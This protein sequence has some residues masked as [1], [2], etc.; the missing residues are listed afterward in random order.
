MN[1]FLAWFDYFVSTAP[2]NE[3]E[4]EAWMRLMCGR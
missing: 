2:T 1:R 3:M 4:L